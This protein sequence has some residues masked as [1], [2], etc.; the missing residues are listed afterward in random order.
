MEKQR[1]PKD[2]KSVHHSFDHSLV[3][4]I[5]H[6]MMR[7]MLL[8]EYQKRVQK[9][10]S[11]SMRAFSEKVGIDQSLLS[12]LIS[13]KRNFS[14][15]TAKEA[16]EFLGVHVSRVLKSETVNPAQRFEQLQEDQFFLIADWYHFA[17]LELIKTKGF[18]SES[19]AIA[20]RLDVPV[21]LISQALERLERLGFIKRR[22]GKWDLSKASNLWSDLKSTNAA[23]KSLQRA[24]HE[25]S[26]NAI[27]D[28]SFDM[29]EH[30]TLTVAVN[31]ALM[32]EVKK[33]IEEFKAS[34]D[35]FIE[36]NG[37]ATE[38]YNLCVSF[39]PLTSSVK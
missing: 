12:K 5:D 18:K 22:N 11:F 36:E 38:V 8:N 4:A 14:A 25:K 31:P 32:P 16:C 13:G 29:R 30:S 24:L 2:V 1:R 34:L 21:L 15:R 39:Y 26:L 19:A 33:R 6:L 20:H 10:P 35:Q 17:I 27:D 9:N 28:V 7:N 23:R 3:Q 37:P